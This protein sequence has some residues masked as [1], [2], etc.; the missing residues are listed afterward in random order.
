MRK[1]PEVG[2]RHNQ[3]FYF[4]RARVVRIAG[5][6]GTDGASERMIGLKGFLVRVPSKRQDSMLSSMSFYVEG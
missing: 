2:G 6:E 4:P 3:R 5:G 1:R